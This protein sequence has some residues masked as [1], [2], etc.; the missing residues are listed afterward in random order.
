LD[1]IAGDCGLVDFKNVGNGQISIDFECDYGLIE[2]VWYTIYDMYNE[3]F[4]FGEGKPLPP[5][6]V[7]L[8]EDT[9]PGYSGGI[10]RLTGLVVTTVT[11]C[12]IF[13]ND[14]PPANP[15]A[16]APSGQPPWWPF[17]VSLPPFPRPGGF[18]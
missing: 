17:P 4:H 10:L 1:A 16:G 7:F 6:R 9:V 13:P 5:S 2:Y 3:K 12:V 14:E 15:P 11:W 8:V 18:H